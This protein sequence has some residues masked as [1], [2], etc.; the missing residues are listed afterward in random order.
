MSVKYTG[1][2]KWFATDGQSYG[3]VRYQKDEA[4][5][6]VFVHYKSI[7]TSGLRAEDWT[8]AKWN[9]VLR[10]GDVVS[11]ELSQGFGQ[12]NGTQASNVEIIKQAAE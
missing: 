8:G 6:E 12:E 11:F 9:K 4:W 10:K 5:Q 1:T 2:C 3:F 7:G